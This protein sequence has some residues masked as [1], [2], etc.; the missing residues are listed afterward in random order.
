MEETS[1]A[2]APREQQIANLDAKVMMEV[3]PGLDKCS[4]NEVEAFIKFCQATDMNPWMR[5]VYLV[6]Y[7]DRQPAS[8]V[9]GNNYYVRKSAENPT[10]GGHRHGVIVQN[11]DF[12]AS[13]NAIYRK[14]ALLMPG[15]T[16][17]GAWIYVTRNGVDDFEWSVTFSEYNKGQATWNEKKA[18][19]VCKVVESQGLR[20]A[21]P[22]AFGAE[23]QAEA[24][25]GIRVLSAEE[26]SDE[27]AE[28]FVEVDGTVVA[29]GDKVPSYPD[30]TAP[31]GDGEYPCPL[32]EGATFE[33]QRQGYYSHAIDGGYC[34]AASAAVRHVWDERIS[35]LFEGLRVTDT[36]KKREWIGAAFPDININA[37]S[38]W[39]PAVY[40]D[41]IYALETAAQAVAQPPEEPKVEEQAPLATL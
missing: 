19:M 13:G 24:Q 2:L 10:Y 22:G 3:L 1:T 14:G 6:K 15:D 25:A 36:D 37:P 31:P 18:T 32:H 17:V 40:Y 28:A 16:L 39:G 26:L 11:R 5:E 9:P 27:Q 41:I 8:I 30:A 12:D 38:R 7:Q 35:G 20:K 34:A 23:A 33:K 29:E 21:I 4:V